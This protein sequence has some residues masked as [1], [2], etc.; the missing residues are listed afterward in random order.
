MALVFIYGPPAAGK[1]TVANELAKLTK[2]KVFHN[3]ITVDMVRSI[4]D[5]KSK[6]YAKLIDLYRLEM[7]EAAAKEH[8]GLIFTFVYDKP[9]DDYF[10]RETIQ[11]VQRHGGKVCFVQLYCQKEE[12]SKRVK[13]SSRAKFAKIRSKAKLH[14][15]INKYD[16]FSKVPYKRSLSIDNT[17]ISPRKVAQEIKSHYKL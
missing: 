6:A 16:L 8:Q 1:L 15:V 10:I 2:Y 9:G 17:D 14:R 3:H 7:F 5:M 13:H 4:F 12:L 11:R